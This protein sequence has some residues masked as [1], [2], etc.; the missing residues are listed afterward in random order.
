VDYQSALDLFD[1]L[2]TTMTDDAERPNDLGE[3]VTRLHAKET[4]DGQLRAIVYN[5]IFTIEAPSVSP[6]VY[7]TPTAHIASTHRTAKTSS[8]IDCIVHCRCGSMF[9]ET[10]LVQCYACQVRLPTDSRCPGQ[11][12]KLSLI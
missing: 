10:T 11:Y 2:K 6:I 3:F 7:R 5:M 9:D 4:V 1:H 12:L 8:L